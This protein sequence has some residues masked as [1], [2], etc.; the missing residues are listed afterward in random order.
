MTQTDPLAL[1]H[2]A[3]I[4][5]VWE[6]IAL[7]RRAT[8]HTLTQER[9]VFWRRRVRHLRRQVMQ[10]HSAEMAREVAPAPVV[11]GWFAPVTETL[12]RAE[13]HFAALLAETASDQTKDAAA[14]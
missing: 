4:A 2:G 13:A 9:A 5:L 8:R 6:Q 1:R 7:A 3:L 10:A 11:D 14:R 12:N